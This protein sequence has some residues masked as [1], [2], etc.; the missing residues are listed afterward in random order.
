M[1]MF[2]PQMKT[3]Y[4]FK[5]WKFYLEKLGKVNQHAIYLL[6]RTFRNKNFFYSDQAKK[7]H[8]KLPEL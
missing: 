8:W 2:I 1:Q 7:F 6:P 4:E 3:P 5:T